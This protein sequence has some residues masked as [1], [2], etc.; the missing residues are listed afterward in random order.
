[1]LRDLIDTTSG[2]SVAAVLKTTVVIISALVLTGA[3]CASSD[4]ALFD[5]Y[6]DDDCAE[7]EHCIQNHCSAECSRDADCASGQF[8]GAYQR[9]DERDPIEVCLDPD[10]T[11]TGC[12]S[13][14]ECRELL[15]DEDAR[16]GI[17]DTCVLTPPQAPDNH[18][19]SQAA[20]H[21]QHD[22]NDDNDEE[23]PH[24]IL[25]VEQ[26]ESSAGDDSDDT[27]NDGDNPDDK[28]DSSDD[29][30]EAD[31]TTVLPVRIGAVI[32]RDDRGD[33]VGYGETRFID[34]DNG[35]PPSDLA[36]FPLPSNACID[37]P[38]DAPYTS[39]AGPGG[40]AY[41]ELLGEYHTPT[42]LGDGYRIQILA[43]GPECPIGGTP[44]HDD[45]AF[46]TY[47]AELCETD[48]PDVLEDDAC[49]ESFH[50]PHDQFADLEVT[51]LE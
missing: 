34:A 16:C 32:V 46:G 50:G 41:I 11:D 7:A 36:G 29:S 15:D 18:N 19:E 17:H 45:F 20:N 10:E 3:D 21:G 48:D 40:R 31:Q 9:E 33:A 37:D 30:E 1:M 28:D 24:R 23:L 25:V 44:D 27:D 4:S 42:D 47:G 43:N 39:L 14:A 2:F 22:V 12:E 38:E 26:L 13:D 5:C 35:D 6:H 51:S 49:F 8:C